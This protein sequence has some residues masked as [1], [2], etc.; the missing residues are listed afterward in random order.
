MS[1]GV[2]QIA[3]V[4]ESRQDADTA[5]VLADRLFLSHAEWIEKD[6]L[7][8]YRAWRGATAE[9]SFLAWRNVRHE[10]ERKGIRLTGAFP[11][12]PRAASPDAHAARRA[13]LVL[14]WDEQSPDGVLL[15]RDADAQPA[16]RAGLEHARDHS[17]WAARV[18][19]AVAN[20]KREAWVLAAFEPQTADETSELVSLREE[21]GFSPTER[22][23]DLTA[24]GELD[25][26][27]AKRV[28]RRL[29]LNEP[30]REAAALTDAP[31]PLLELRGKENGLSAYLSEVRERLVPLFAPAR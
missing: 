25:K 11:T 17:P 22:S 26:R 29:G 13:L 7:P 16:R 2:K 9:H 10:A 12:D 21:L 3:I 23:H 31:L 18:A 6:S 30:R 4:C 24:S 15:M 28:H 14:E 27:S 1:S 5:A 20:P 8:D 19:V